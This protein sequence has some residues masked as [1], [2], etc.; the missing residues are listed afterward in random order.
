VAV[1]TDII[2]FYLFMGDE[3]SPPRMYGA[4]ISMKVDV[5]YTWVNH[6][7]PEWQQFKADASSKYRDIRDDLHSSVFD[8]AR[9]HN[10]NEIFYSILSLQKYAPWVNRIFIV[11]NCSLPD[12]VEAD[13][14]IIRVDHREIFTSQDGLPTFNAFAIEACLHRVPGLS[15]HFIYFNDD[16]FLLKPVQKKDFFPEQNKVSVFPSRHAIPTAHAPNLRPVEYSMVNVRN[17]LMR[18]FSFQSDRKLH[19]AP[20]PLLRSV[21]FEIEKRYRDQLLETES[22]QLRSPSDLPLSTT[23]HAYYSLAT[24]RG[25]IKEVGA[26]YIDIGNPLFI[27]LVMPGSPLRRGKYTFLCLNEIT[28]IK[29]GAIIRDWIVTRLMKTLFQ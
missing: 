20:F 9:F 22:H 7:D 5:V 14:R 3:I 11:T 29:F 15:E 6:L 25:R 23:L 27:F 28:S 19:H 4:L 24:G 21:M 18:D 16:V 2:E 1:K 26:R 10:R 13:S 8:D 17:L 12:W